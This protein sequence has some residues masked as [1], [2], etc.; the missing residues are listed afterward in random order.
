MGF[1]NESVLRMGGKNAGFWL[2]L[3]WKQCLILL[4]L[5]LESP[6]LSF[7]CPGILPW[8]KATASVKKKKK[9][10]HKQFKTRAQREVSCHMNSHESQKNVSHSHLYFPLIPLQQSPWTCI[11][12]TAS[13]L[14]FVFLM[15][16]S[17]TDLSILHM[18]LDSVTSPPAL[19]YSVTPQIP[20]H[21]K[22]YF[23]P[24]HFQ[25]ASRVSLKGLVECDF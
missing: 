9:Q 19:P 4:P 15:L 1:P 8:F 5:K 11:S 16:R 6:K 21:G 13:W 22:V 17:P 10:H 20:P 25:F 18:F 24:S 7:L 23:I 14:H 3:H 12:T 2:Q